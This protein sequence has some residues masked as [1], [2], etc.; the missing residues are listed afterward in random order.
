[1]SNKVGLVTG[2]SRGIGKQV[3][4]E[5]GAADILVLCASRKKEDSEK[6]AN[7]I[8][9]S[10]GKAVGLALDVSDHG[11]IHSFV[12]GILNEYGKVDILINNAGISMD[13]G[14]LVNTSLNILQTTLGTNLIGPFLLAQAILP[15]MQKN[16][17]GRIVNVSSGMG[18]LSDMGSGYAAYRISKTALNALTRI[19]HS[20]TR[21]MDIK[22]NSVCPGWVR[23]D[24]GGP[25]ANRPVEKG[26]ETIVWAALLDSKGPSGCFFRDR[27]VI[28]W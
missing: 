17:Y 21:E 4:K 11:S 14:P 12:S 9:N 3:A 16:G 24:M 26:A 7:E 28:P 13:K 5:L 2:A 10:G 20:E 18:Q 27:N 6:T 25:S 19:L 23:T 1:M 22:V 8:R 15:A